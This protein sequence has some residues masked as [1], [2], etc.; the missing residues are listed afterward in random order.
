MILIQFFVR[1]SSNLVDAAM[2]RIVHGTKVLTLGGPDMLFQ[3]SFGIFPGEKLIKSYAC[4]LSTSSGPVI[5][6]LYVST[7]RL[8]Y[9]SDYPCHYSLPQQQNQCVY[10]KVVVRVDQLSTVNPSS[11]RFNPSEK[12]IQLVTVDGYEFYFMGFI[13]YDKALK[14]I[15]EAIQ[16]YHNHSRRSLSGQEA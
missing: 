16:Q 12:Y 1:I 13:A 7:K 2:A 10:Y 9:C 15:R 5:G 4:Y 11:N 8:A 3:Q 6:T 14:T